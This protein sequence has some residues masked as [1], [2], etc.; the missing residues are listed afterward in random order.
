ME[1]LDLK[2]TIITADALNTQKGTVRRSE[3][4]NHTFLDF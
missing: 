3:I 2:N 4:I 1:N